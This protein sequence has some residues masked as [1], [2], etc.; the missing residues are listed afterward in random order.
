MGQFNTAQGLDVTQAHQRSRNLLA[1]FHVRQQ[2]SAARERHR[3]GSLAVQNARGFLERAW[4]AEFKKRQAHHGASTFSFSRRGFSRRGT[5]FIALPSPRSQGGGTRRA[6]GQL[7]CGKWPGPKRGSRPAFFSARAF[8]IF[9]GV[10][11]ISSIRTPTASYTALATAGM[12]GRSGPCPTSFAPNGPR[13]SGASINSVITS[14][15]S[16]DVGLL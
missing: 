7:T 11:G 9:S 3:I 2:V 13:G 1:A 16:R 6:C 8:I 5:S 12:I 15:M 4:R 14:G 10:T